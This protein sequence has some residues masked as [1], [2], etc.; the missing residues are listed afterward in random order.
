MLAGNP[1]HEAFVEAAAKATVSFAVNSIVNV[2][3]EATSVYCGDP[4]AAHETAC[5]A[6]AGAHTVPLFEK[7]DLVIVGCG[8]SPFDLNMIQAHKALDTAAR[9]CSDG[10]PYSVAECS[11]GLGRD[12]FLDWFSAANS[13]EGCPALRQI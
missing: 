10:G 5:A 13:Q 1:V 6:F 2:A 9:A 12:D 8:G 7:R 11:D 3:G 4:I